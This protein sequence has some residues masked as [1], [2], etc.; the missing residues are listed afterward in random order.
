MV[1]R[2]TVRAGI[3]IGADGRQ[4]TVAGLVKARTYVEGANASGIV[5]G[6]FENHRPGWVALAFR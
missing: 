5:F 1:A 3:V 4:S 6:Y 2:T